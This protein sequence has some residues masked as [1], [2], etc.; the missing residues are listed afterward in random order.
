[1]SVHATGQGCP[2]KETPD[3]PLLKTVNGPLCNGAQQIPSLRPGPSTSVP[4]PCPML[5]LGVQAQP[6]PQGLCISALLLSPP[7]PPPTILLSLDWSC[8]QRPLG[9][10]ACLLHQPALRE[11]PWSCKNW[12]HDNCKAGSTLEEDL[13]E[14][15]ASYH[16]ALLPHC[17]SLPGP[18]QGTLCPDFSQR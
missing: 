14:Q 10:P 4:R 6:Q 17:P 15:G 7:P 1:M 5:H 11:G 13:R 3:G 9:T 8:P 2:V 16:T 18:L 12:T